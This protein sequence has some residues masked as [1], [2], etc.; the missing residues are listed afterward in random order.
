M[1]LWS[2]VILIVTVRFFETHCSFLRPSF[3][4][5]PSQGLLILTVTLEI[6]SFIWLSRSLKALK[7][8]HFAR[9]IAKTWPGGKLCHR[10][11][12]WKACGRSAWAGDSCSCPSGG[13]LCRRRHRRTA[14]C[15]GGCVGAC[16][17]SKIDWTPCRTWRSD[18]ASPTCGWSCDDTA[19]TL[20]E[21]L[22]RTPVQRHHGVKS[23]CCLN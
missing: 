10:E 1:N 2:Y 3:I 17:A 18:E 7:I 5:R 9:Q 20:V 8:D 22:C 15:R 6:G 19:S 11:H 12:I 23:N 16:W 21:S 4:P 13:T 14:W